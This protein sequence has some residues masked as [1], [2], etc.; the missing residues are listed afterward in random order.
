VR[1]DDLKILMGKELSDIIYV[2]Q[3]KV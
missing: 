2:K 3:I 1:I